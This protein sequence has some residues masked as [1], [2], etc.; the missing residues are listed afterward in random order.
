MSDHQYPQQ[1]QQP[2]WGGPPQVPVHGAP[3]PPPP[4]KR[5]VGKVAG[6]GCLGVLG[7][8]VVIGIAG[9]AGGG[10]ADQNG[11]GNGDSGASDSSSSVHNEARNE[12][13][14]DSD[15]GSGARSQ[16]ADFKSC[17]AK[18]GTATE[19]A[20]VR[21]VT[22]VT[23]ADRRNN[24]LDAPE[25]FTDFS[26]GLTGPHQGE[27][28]LVASAFSSCYESDN[29]LVTVYDRTGEILANGTF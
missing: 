19:R 20:A 29:G 15:D 14:N 28:K 8:V 2:G 12:A 27:G 5:G 7:L 25:V 26:G 21:H 6:L 23:G 24:I 9:M 3:A 16:A 22:K 17:V 13:K 10:G 18:N 4:R 1:Q 11:N